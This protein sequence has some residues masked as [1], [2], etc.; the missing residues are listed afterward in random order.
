MAGGA[1]ANPSSPTGTPVSTQGPTSSVFTPRFS[2]LPTAP[3]STAP[4]ATYSLYNAPRQ[5]FAQPGAAY[6]PSSSFMPQSVS[7]YGRFPVAPTSTAAR[8]TADQARAQM[9]EYQQRYKP[10]MQQA[11]QEVSQYAAGLRQAEANRQAEIARRAEEARQAAAAAAAAE[12][13]RIR[14][15][16]EA[17]SQSYGE[18]YSGATGGLASL[19]GFN[20]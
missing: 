20:K 9:M 11:Q 15:E 17:A 13:E 3:T 19:Q 12:A 2:T 5:G 7:G 1:S 8:P 4:G 6:Q 10:G 18:W 14:R 16:Q